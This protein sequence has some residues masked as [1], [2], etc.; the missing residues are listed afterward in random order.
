MSG[1]LRNDHPLIIDKP[2]VSDPRLIPPITPVRLHRFSDSPA[3]SSSPSARSF[4][5]STLPAASSSHVFQAAAR[6]PQASS[7]SSIQQPLPARPSLSTP[8]LHRSAPLARFTS[9]RLMRGSGDP[10]ALGNWISH[11]DFAR[12]IL[13]TARQFRASR[14]SQISVRSPGRDASGIS[15]PPLSVHSVSLELP[16]EMAAPTL[17]S[18]TQHLPAQVQ[19]ESISLEDTDASLSSVV[20]AELSPPPLATSIPRG[21]SRSI[22]VFRH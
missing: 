13:N 9:T 2:V 8:L 22:R 11:P 4:H 6:F 5:S 14:T 18:S 10:L 17:D 19:L 16:F 15:M 12:G 7:V 21:L 20:T 1:S 3:T